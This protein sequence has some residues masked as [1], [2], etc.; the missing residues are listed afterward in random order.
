MILNDLDF[1]HCGKGRDCEGRA[2]QLVQSTLGL[3]R[4]RRWP[5]CARFYSLVARRQGLPRHSASPFVIYILLFI[6]YINF[7]IE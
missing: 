2:H 4:R 1:G 6:Y 7:A 5:Q 3:N